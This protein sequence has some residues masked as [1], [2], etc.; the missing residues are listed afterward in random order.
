MLWCVSVAPLGK[1]VVPEVYWMLIGSSNCR[2]L[3]ASGQ[4][5][6]GDV[7]RRRRAARPSRRRGRR[8]CS[9][10]G[11][12]RPGLLPACGGVGGLA[13]AAAQQQD[14]HAGLVQ[15][16]LQLAGLV[17]GVDVDEDRADA[18]GGVLDDDPLE[19][20][21]RP[22]ADAVAVPDAEGEQ[23]AGESRG[24]SPELG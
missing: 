22:D 9:Q 12:A 6:F 10:V 18:G 1:P 14:A 17:G 24:R 21:G 23:A 7:V 5:G 3:L 8:I 4:F 13:E 11:A 2:R 19:A 16:V 20:V 15:D